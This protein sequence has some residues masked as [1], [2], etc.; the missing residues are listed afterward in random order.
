MDDA[1]FWVVVLVAAV[2]FAGDPDLHDVIMA[3]VGGDC[4]SIAVDP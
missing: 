3:R 4:A 2:L 1:A